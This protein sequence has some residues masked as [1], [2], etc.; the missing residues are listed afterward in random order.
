M[1]SSNKK[2]ASQQAIEEDNDLDQ[3]LEE[4][5]SRQSSEIVKDKEFD[6]Q[7]ICAEEESTDEKLGDV[8]VE[9]E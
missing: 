7:S 1:A 6:V 2:V 3:Q 9:L 5:L 8:T 4:L